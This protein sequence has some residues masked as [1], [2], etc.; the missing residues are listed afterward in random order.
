MKSVNAEFIHDK[1]KN[2]HA[3]GDPD[4]QSGYIDK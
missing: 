2:H 1:K 4:G 3:Y